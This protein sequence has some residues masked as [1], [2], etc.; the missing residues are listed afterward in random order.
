MIKSVGIPFVEER[1]GP[2][3]KSDFEYNDSES[4]TR[5]LEYL[6]FESIDYIGYDEQINQVC[7]GPKKQ[8]RKGCDPVR[9]SSVQHNHHL[10]AFSTQHRQSRVRWHLNRSPKRGK[11]H[12][13]L[14][15]AI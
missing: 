12:D 8:L 15:I 10:E 3:L 7:K 1:H 5:D 11:Y 14:G 2:L 9:H 6:T 4:L 13:A